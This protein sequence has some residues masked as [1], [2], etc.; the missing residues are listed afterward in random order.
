[1]TRGFLSVVLV[2]ITSGAMVLAGVET[3][4]QSA[5]DGE[6]AMAVMFGGMGLLLGGAALFGEDRKQ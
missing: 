4:T 2:L 5:C 3:F 1:V 6:K